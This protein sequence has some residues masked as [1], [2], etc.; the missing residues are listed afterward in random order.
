MERPEE[1]W[2]ELSLDLPAAKMNLSEEVSRLQAALFDAQ[3]RLQIVADVSGGLIGKLEF[4]LREDDSL[5][6]VSADAQADQL[7][8]KACAAFLGQPLLALLPGLSRRC[9][10]PCATWRC[11]AA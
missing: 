10:R 3:R 7:L 11:A 5:L 1:S 2:T 6:L 8:G 4:E 9:R